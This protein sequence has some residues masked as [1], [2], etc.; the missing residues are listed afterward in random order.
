VVARD[1]AATEHYVIAILRFALDAPWRLN[2]VELQRPKVEV[3]L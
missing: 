3:Q 1:A 2:L